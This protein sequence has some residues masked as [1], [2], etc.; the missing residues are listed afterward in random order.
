[1]RAI[2]QVR[3]VHGLQ[4]ACSLLIYS[5]KLCSGGGDKRIMEVKTDFKERAKPKVGSKD[6]MTYQPGKKSKVR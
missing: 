1:M 3:K 5:F 4:R 6:N 2:S